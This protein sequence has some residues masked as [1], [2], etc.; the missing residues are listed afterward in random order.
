MAARRRYARPKAMAEYVG[1]TP[2]ALYMQRRRGTGFPYIRSGRRSILYDLDLV[3]A[4]LAERTR[5]AGDLEAPEA[6]A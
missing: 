6:R 2:P 3:D 5:G 4:W 1:S